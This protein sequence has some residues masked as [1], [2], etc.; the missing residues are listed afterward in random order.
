M[1]FSG[2]NSR[3]FPV[4]HQRKYVSFVDEHIY[5]VKFPLTFV[6]V[7]RGFLRNSCKYELGSLR[8]APKGGHSIR[9]VPRSL[10]RHLALRTRVP[11]CFL[12][13]GIEDISS[14]SQG[15]G[16]LR[17]GDLIAQVRF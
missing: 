14:F 15:F 7:F 2:A 12:V 16:G 1:H 9:L 8:N 13:L 17:V 5:S 10:V 6:E 11:V 3:C 4:F